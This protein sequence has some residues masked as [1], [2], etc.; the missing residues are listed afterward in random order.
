LKLAIVRHGKAEE[1]APSGADRDRVLTPR[2]HRQAE[3]LAE[4][5]AAIFD[6]AEVSER[7]ILTSDFARALATARIIER[8]VACPLWMEASLQVGHDGTSAARLIMDFAHLSGLI[9]VGHNPQLSALLSSLAPTS[10]AA[11]ESLSTG[12]AA[13][14]TVDAGHPMGSGKLLDRLRLED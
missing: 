2:G 11:A 5:L 12:E 7:L 10:A 6:P 13:I 8:A 4:R 1:H 3:F 9:M 14:L